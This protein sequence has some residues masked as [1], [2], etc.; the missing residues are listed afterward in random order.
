MKVGTVKSILLGFTL[1]ALP[2][3]ADPCRVY[4]EATAALLNDPVIR[5]ESKHFNGQVLRDDA[6]AWAIASSVLFEADVQGEIQDHVKSLGRA[7]T[8]QLR[9]K[10][11]NRINLYRAGY[12][13]RLSGNH[14]LMPTTGD[15]LVVGCANG[16]ECGHLAVSSPTRT[17]HYV[18]IEPEA[19]EMTAVEMSFIA[20]FLPEHVLGSGFVADVTQ[21]PL[22]THAYDGIVLN[23]TAA[24]FPPRTRAVTM[25][26][27]SNALRGSGTLLIQ[28]VNLTRSGDFFGFFRDLVHEL[29][30]NEAPVTDFELALIAANFGGVLYEAF[31]EGGLDY[32][33]VW[34]DDLV[35]LLR[36]DE[37]FS[38]VILE[39]RED[40]FRIVATKKP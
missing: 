24:F 5:W 13:W 8:D 9:R 39:R 29:M 2:L 32:H 22:S 10:A 3:F 23:D 26:S 35:E 16:V 31:G 12:R 28:D 11:E 14:Q 19:V 18:N 30:E 37:T 38:S 15:V 36:A 7:A 33:G 27:L 4:I 1:L 17:I 25:Q 34:D 6:S 21:F 40:E 20:N